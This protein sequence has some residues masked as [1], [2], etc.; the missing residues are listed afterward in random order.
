MKQS[1][2]CESEKKQIIFATYSLAHEGLD[3]PKL[4]TLFL[5]TPKSDIVQSIGR[6]LRENS[7]IE[8]Q[9]PLIYDVIDYWGVFEYQYYKRS[10]F[11]KKNRI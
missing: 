3:I 9:Y 4:D 7:S 5:S 6:I 10:K 8:K 1:E 11:Y 2:L